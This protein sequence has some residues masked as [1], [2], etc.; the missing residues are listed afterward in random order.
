MRKFHHFGL[1]T[2]QP[3]ADETYV[4]ATKVFVTDPMKHPQKIE[5]LR[6]EAD[7][8]LTGPVRD[9]PHIAFATDDMG[10]EIEGSKV[11]LGPFEAMP[12]LR[13]IFVEKDGAVFEF[14]EFAE[15]MDWG[16]SDH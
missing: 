2:D 4:P 12:G 1:P 5:F 11:L 10:P 16:A 13:V 6:F 8:D 14:M 9:M 3:Q 7:A 15:G